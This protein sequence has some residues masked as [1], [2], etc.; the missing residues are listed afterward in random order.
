MADWASFLN[1]YLELADYPILADKGT[2][3]A[4]TAKLKA[5]SEFEVFRQRQDQDYVSDFDRE[6]TRLEGQKTRKP[7]DEPA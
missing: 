4:L 5:E 2:V 1:R 3:S 7:P 6:I